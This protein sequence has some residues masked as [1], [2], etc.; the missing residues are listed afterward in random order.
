MLLSLNAADAVLLRIK[1]HE[2]Q[3]TN[4]NSTI[5]ANPSLYVIAKLYVC[6]E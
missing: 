1:I 3:T 5:K 4:I 6:N 2:Y